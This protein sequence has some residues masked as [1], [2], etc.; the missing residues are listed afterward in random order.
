M[1]RKLVEAETYYK[2]DNTLHIQGE[3]GLIVYQ[4]FPS[5]NIQISLVHT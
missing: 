3:K 2:N 5:S 4:Y 1:L